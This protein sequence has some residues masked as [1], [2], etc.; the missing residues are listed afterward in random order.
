MAA[1]AGADGIAGFIREGA[2]AAVATGVSPGNLSISASRAL[3]Q[4]EGAILP[5]L[6]D[7]FSRHYLTRF[8]H[9]RTV[10]INTTASGGNADLMSQGESD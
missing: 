5:L 2:I 9:E 3:A 6:D 8:C 1:G 4:R 10:S 7:A